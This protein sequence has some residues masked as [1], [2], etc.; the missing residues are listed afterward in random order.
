MGGYNVPRMDHV[1][2]MF[3]CDPDY[4]VLSEIR[5]NWSETLPH[6]V[7]LIRLQIR[8][9]ELICTWW[10]NEKRTDLLTM[11]RE[12]IFIRIDGNCMH[13]QFMGRT[14][15]TDRDFLGVD[16]V[17]LGDFEDAVGGLTPLFAT[18]ILVNGPE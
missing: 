9:R 7:S 4:V 3:Q 5:R 8:V 14:K 11:S 17:K 18:R 16:R 1:H 13:S 10:I 15:N 2:A 6:L 12:A